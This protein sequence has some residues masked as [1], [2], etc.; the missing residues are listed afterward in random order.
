MT[1]MKR[2]ALLI[3]CML[4]TLI[5]LPVGGARVFLSVVAGFGWRWWPVVLLAVSAGAA[6]LGDKLEGEQ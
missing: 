5:G 1:E 2:D 6:V 3:A 4:L